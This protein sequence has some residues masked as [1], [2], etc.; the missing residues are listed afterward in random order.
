[1]TLT[2]RNGIR[3]VGIAG[4]I[5]AG[6]TL[7]ASMIPGAFT[8]QWAD[9]IYRG[10]AATLGVSEEMLR[11]RT[12]KERTIEVAGVQLVPRQLLQT[13]GTEW[14]REMVHTELWVRLTL[15]RIEAEAAAGR[16]AFAVC[17][18]RFHNEVSA[19]R[20][21][22][23]EVWWIERPGTATGGHTSDL[24]LSRGSCDR[25]V[26]NDGTIETLRRRVVAAWHA[27]TETP[28]CLAG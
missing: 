12:N 11:D 18:T 14:G 24:R 19:I 23:G 2:A 26:E 7:A 25:V 6:K 1:M 10:L 27:Y 28:P 3:I 16:R 4:C 13:L 20:A 21:A 8:L 5:G 22:G 17:G 9:P 15:A